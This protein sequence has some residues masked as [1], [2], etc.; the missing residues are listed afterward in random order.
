MPIFE[1]ASKLQS[2]KKPWTSEFLGEVIRRSLVGSKGVH[3]M[4][5]QELDKRNGLIDQRFE[6]LKKE[7]KMRLKNVSVL[8][9]DINNL[10]LE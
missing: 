3:F 4:D 7:A 1:E 6:T 5:E 9:N 10:K 2:D 8:I